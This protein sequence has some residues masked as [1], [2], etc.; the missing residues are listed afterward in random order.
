MALTFDDGS[1]PFTPQ[2]L[3][4]LA[5]FHVHATFF[6]TGVGDT[7]YP[8][9][10]RAIVADGDELGNHTYDHPKNWG[11]RSDF[12]ATAQRLELTRTN[13]VLAR[14]IGHPPCVMRPP[15]GAYDAASLAMVRSLGMTLAMWTT[16]T[17]DWR[18]PPY[19]S[20][21]AQ[22]TIVRN[23]EEGAEMRHPIILMH[24]AKASHEPD[25]AS[26]GCAFGQV[27]SFRGNT[28]AA[29]PAII[30]FYRAHGY[31]FVVL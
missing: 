31:R 26:I 28:V 4:V 1:G 12:R 2:I 3:A 21:A 9:Y 30:R 14:L 8:Q 5:R 10:A 15:G 20:H 18:Q 11:Y 22:L 16:D 13:A 19:L 6:D 17:E 23:A 29:L 25:C 27:S 24:A 7:R